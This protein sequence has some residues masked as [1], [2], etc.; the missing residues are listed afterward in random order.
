MAT[1]ETLREDLR[2]DLKDASD[3]LWADALLERH[4]KHAVSDFSM[5]LPIETKA[6]KA[7]VSA[8][9]EVDV[10]ALHPRVTIYAV[11]YP[12]DQWPQVF[13]QFGTFGDVLTLLLDTA[14][15][16]SNCYIYYGTPHT[17]PEDDD[18][19]GTTAYALGDY[20][21]PVTQNGF[22]YECTTAGTSGAGEPTWPT[23]VGDTV[24]DN[25]A[26]WTCRLASFSPTYDETIITGAGGYAL[27]E[28]AA[29]T[30]NLANV[31]GKQVAMGY[32]I[33]GD[34]RLSWFKRRLKELG[35]NNRVRARA[36]YTP[37]QPVV[38]RFKVQGP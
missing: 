23:T 19:A 2:L 4:I 1:L 28:Y 13:A 17:A 5:A 32:R 3:V 20:V 11:E 15:D 9:R 12:V 16:G 26:V 36:L 6:T 10:S 30:I 8:S 22:R 35:E 21:V 34:R 37:A 24:A 31:G 29:N 27:L 14:P 33:E 25:T 38:S 7:T 18:W